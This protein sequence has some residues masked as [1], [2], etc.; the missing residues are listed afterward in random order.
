MTQYG[1]GMLEQ[2]IAQACPEC[3]KAR[4]FVGVAGLGKP[5]IVM[6]LAT[7]YIPSCTVQRGN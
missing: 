1:N 6:P 2:C 7:N 4:V 3:Y 5:S